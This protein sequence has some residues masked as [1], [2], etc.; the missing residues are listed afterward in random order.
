MEVKS[1][2]PSKKVKD[3]SQVADKS[4]ETVSDA[5]DS[6]T[7]APNDEENTPAYKSSTKASGSRKVTNGEPEAADKDS[8]PGTDQ[9]LIPHGERMPN[10]PTQLVT[11]ISSEA[12]GLLVLEN[13]WDRWVDIYVRTEET[14]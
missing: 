12:F 6:V 7:V 13:Q 2:P 9:L 3:N 5:E 11:S 10:Y 14:L 8:D 1:E 4:S